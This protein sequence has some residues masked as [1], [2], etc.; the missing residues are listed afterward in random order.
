MQAL[1]AKVERDL[2]ASETESLDVD[3][4]FTIAYQS[5]LGACTIALVASGYQPAKGESSH[6]RAIESLAKTI[7]ASP[8]VVRQ[9]DAFRKKRNLTSY[10][11]A[12]T[13]SER[14]ATEMLTL[15]KSLRDQVLGWLAANHAALIGPDNEGK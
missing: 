6:F 4:R 2:R 10:E 14:E 9:L 5:A 3:W 12:G 11:V 15:A 7:G 8:F 1:L 13:I